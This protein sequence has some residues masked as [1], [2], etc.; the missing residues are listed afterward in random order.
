[1]PEPV[2]SA[3]LE[4][5]Q[6]WDEAFSAAGYKNAFIIKV[7]PTNADPMDIRSQPQLLL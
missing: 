2:K 1:M 5:A 4:G 6:W 7:L 3:L